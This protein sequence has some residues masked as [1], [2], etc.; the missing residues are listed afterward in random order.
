MLRALPPSPRRP[1]P[2][3]RETALTAQDSR[4]SAWATAC[5]SRGSPLLRSAPAPRPSVTRRGAREAARAPPRLR[6]PRRSRAAS[7]PG[8]AWLLPGATSTT[9]TTPPSFA[10]A[11]RRPRAGLHPHHARCR[12][13]RS[14][15]ATAAPRGHR[16]TVRRA[17]RPAPGWPRKPRGLKRSVGRFTLCSAQAISATWE[18]SIG[19]PP[20][21]IGAMMSAAGARRPR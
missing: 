10:R 15:A 21:A 14:R 9:P 7:N 18:T 4:S 2:L 20:S 12:T 11:Q 8:G 5:P 19:L 3:D 1:R 13:P 16:P 6:A 17:C